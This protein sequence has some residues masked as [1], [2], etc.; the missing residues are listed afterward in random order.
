MPPEAQ[1]DWE[2]WRIVA[3]ERFSVGLVELE[4]DWTLHDLCRASLALDI[5]EDAEIL[6]LPQSK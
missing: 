2:V 3:S 4:R 1:E 5:I 6:A